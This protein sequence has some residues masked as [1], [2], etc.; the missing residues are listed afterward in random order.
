MIRLVAVL[1]ALLSGSAQHPTMPA[2]MSH[3]EHLK[4]IEKHAALT[5]RG[6][7]TMG[8]DQNTTV[9]HFRLSPTGGSID[10][11]VRRAGDTA[12]RAQIRVHLKQI[13]G[14]F[15]KDN[16]SKPTVIHAE[17]PNGVTQLQKHRDATR[18]RYEETPR[19]ARVVITT[20]EPL[21]LEAVHT[22]LR[23]QIMEHKTGDPTKLQ[24]P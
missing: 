18:Y 17:V 4:Q 8:F 22:F 12:T 19:G 9:H 5:Q 23:Y 6:A 24:Q 20:N 21:A 7:D 16:F 14:D 3:E 2:G 1:A 11:D 13:A 15:A 10:V